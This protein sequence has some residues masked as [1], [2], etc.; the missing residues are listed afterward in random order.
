MPTSRKLRAWRDWLWDCFRVVLVAPELPEHFDGTGIF[1]GSED[2]RGIILLRR[3][4][5]H[6]IWT[7]VHELG[8]ILTERCY[9]VDAAQDGLQWQTT[10]DEQAAD[11]FAC[12]FIID[13]YE[14]LEFMGEGRTVRQFAQYLKVPVSA[15][16]LRSRLMGLMV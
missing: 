12:C 4:T 9:D 10:G 13:E 7:L 1:L 14:L 11:E 8:H 5:E 6:A 15:V 3:G 16:L 2:C